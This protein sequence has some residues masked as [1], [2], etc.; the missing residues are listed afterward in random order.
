ITIGLEAPRD[1]SLYA[2][3]DETGVVV[4]GGD[5]RKLLEAPV[6]SFRDR[7]LF[8]FPVGA[9]VQLGISRSTG[10]LALQRRITEPKQDWALAE[11]IKD[12]A[13]REKMDELLSDLGNLRI[14]DVVTDSPGGQTIPSPLPDE[15]AV[16]Q[17]RVFGVEQPLTIY[18]R[19]VEAPVVE[20]APATIEARVSDR[21][22][23]YRLQSRFLE[24]LPGSADEIRDRSLARIPAE[25]VDSIVIQSRIDP[26]VDLRAS[27]AGNARQWEV[28]IND[29]LVPANNNAI[30]ELIAGVNEAAILNFVA[31]EDPNLADFGLLPPSRRV[32][33]NLRFPSVTRQDGSVVPAQGLERVLNLGWQEGD[34]QRLY[35]HFEGEP[36]VVELDPSF[37]S[38]IPTHPIKWRSLNVLTFNPFHLVSITR[39]LPNQ[40]N[41]KLV[42]ENRRDR[43]EAIKNGTDATDTLDIAAVRR[44]RDRLGS[45]TAKGW[46]L[47]L[48]R[49]NQALETPSAT[50]VI[51][52]NEFDL[53]VGKARP[54]TY[55]IHF[56]EAA[57]TDVYF[58]KV[59]G[60]PDVFYLDSETFRELKRPVTTSQ[61]R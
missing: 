10:Q 40:E 23:V 15:A 34:Q 48:A 18:L 45:L 20:G 38:F 5:V 4:V 3:S 33:F 39:V 55:T 36:G 12:W 52:T 47:S 6:A 61:L 2:R 11:P 54:K 44:L 60:S 27:A 7:R 25:Y 43:W 57:A 59:E 31:D 21:P 24:T 46:F 56:A 30:A 50:F 13:S 51:E 26:H 1:D 37:V 9:I 28:T 35:A 17:V 42:Y 49:A 16:L 8:S 29:K 32:T 41:L 58:G 14:D 22:A 53:A 19:Q